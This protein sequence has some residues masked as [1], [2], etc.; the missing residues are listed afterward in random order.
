MVRWLN[1]LFFC[2]FFAQIAAAQR[3]PIQIDTLYA[4]DYGGAPMVYWQAGEEFD[5]AFFVVER[6]TDLRTWSPLQSVPI[7]TLTLKERREKSAPYRH[8]DRAAPAARPLWYRL[9]VVREIG[10]YSYTH[11]ACAYGEGAPAVWADSWLSPA[12]ELTIHAQDTLTCEL[13]ISALSADSQPLM[14]EKIQ[15]QKGINRLPA[16][17]PTGLFLLQIGSW[18]GLLFGG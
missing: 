7:T 15:L 2:L 17:L 12:G 16:K 8:W 10:I 14:Q 18:R 11:T 5:A 4:Q 9:R 6:S 13:K 3:L 1:S